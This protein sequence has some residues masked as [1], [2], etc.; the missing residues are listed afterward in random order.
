MVKAK[1]TTKNVQISTG[2]SLEFDAAECKEL[3]AALVSVLV[4]LG[5]VEKNGHLR[6]LYV[7]ADLLKEGGFAE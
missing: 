4:T 1:I 3:S 2:V 7:L 5:P 6:M